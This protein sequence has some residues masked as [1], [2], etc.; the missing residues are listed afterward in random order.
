MR[1]APQTVGDLEV[2]N[3]G[4]TVILAPQGVSSMHPH[5]SQ[6]LRPR[7]LVVDD[8]PQQRKLI[9]YLLQ[10]DYDV[11]TAADA[12]TALHLLDAN[13]F[14][15]ALV[16]HR[17]PGMSGTELLAR[18]HALQ[19][20]GIRFLVTACAEHD[21]LQQAINLGQVSR[22]VSKPVDPEFLL[23]DIRR[24]LAHRDAH[25]QRQRASTL[26]AVG[27]L[28]SSVV[29]DLRN[30]LQVVSM[31]PALLQLNTDSAMDNSVDMLKRAEEAMR[32][33][34]D[35]LLL[36]VKGQVPHYELSAYSLATVLTATLAQA[37]KL[38]AVGRHQLQVE[39]APDL[40]ALMLAPQRCQRML[41]NLLRQAAESMPEAGTLGLRAWRGDAQ[42][43]CEI[44]DAGPGVS[45]QV[46]AHAFEPV[47]NLS[48]DAGGG[49]NLPICRAV[50]LAHGGELSLRSPRPEGPGSV[51]L[52]SFPLPVA[53]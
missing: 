31:V 11:Q 27:G 38:G 51:F 3:L 15:V 49:L 29:H 14:D 41:L 13:D 6:Q 50:M 17:M 21:I 8:E 45:P 37:R 19:P 46:L 9:A 7:I 10:K 34:V 33:L 42:V 35:E 23:V 36:L 12:A 44:W 22:F 20:G 53:P 28:A 4:Q 47:F 16:D 5:P 26:A 48:S 39:V 25:D 2:A 43:H 40:P 1:M 52:A 32:D 24:A 18:I 30:C